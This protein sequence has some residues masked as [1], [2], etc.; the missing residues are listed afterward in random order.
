MPEIYKAAKKMTNISFDA[1]IIC[2][3]PDSMEERFIQSI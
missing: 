3:R 2:F 1:S